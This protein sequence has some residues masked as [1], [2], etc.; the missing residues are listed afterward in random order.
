MGKPLNIA[1]RS[2]ATQEEA[3]ALA[4]VLSDSDIVS[5]ITKDSGDLDYVLQGE[6]PT[7]KFEV[8]INEDDHEKAE[9]L[10][11]NL[12]KEDLNSVDKDYYLFTFSD[13]ELKDVLIKKNEW[14]EFDVLLSQKILEERGVDVNLNEIEK[15]RELRDLELQ[16]P[17]GGQT[18]WIIFGYITA[19]IGGFIGILLGYSLWLSKKKLPNGTKVPA[20][21]DDIRKHGKII[22]YLGVIMFVV[23]FTLR[24]T[25]MIVIF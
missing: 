10:L 15:E 8:H 1:L 22:F 4:K 23:L 5:K 3:E 6:A 24:L 25:E 18:G 2:V 11:T 20:Y 16:K 7:N 19:L 21:N 13:D 12:A 14:N 17:E 9:T